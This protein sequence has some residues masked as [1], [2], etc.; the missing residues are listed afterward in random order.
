[1]IEEIQKAL[2]NYLAWLRAEISLREIDNGW[3]KITTPW[4]DRHND[5]I[6]LYA[7]KE[8]GGFLLS[9]DAYTIQDL[10]QSGVS[11]DNSPRRRELLDLTLN[12]FGVELN[13]RA[14]QVHA[15]WEDFSWRKHNLIQ[16][17][18]AVNDMF[19]LASLTVASLF[20]EDVALWLHQHQ[21]SYNSGKKY[22]GKSGY[23]HQFDFVI[24]K[25][26][27]GSPER[28]VQAIN[29]P[30][31]NAVR[32]LIFLW[33]E[34][35]ASRPKGAKLYALLNDK[36]EVSSKVKDALGTYDV[37]AVPWEKRE[38]LAEKLAA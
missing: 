14:L 35:E 25:S 8:D 4:L 23:D 20:K 11:F 18:L 32:Q 6:Q 38:V 34:T 29:H 36:K 31:R 9:D 7:R 3:V 2:D 12:G 26:P 17:I 1:M 19:H 27:Q 30:D 15:S 22:I 28:M 24:P 5:Y 10:E 13:D 21:I 16:A 37:E 33:V